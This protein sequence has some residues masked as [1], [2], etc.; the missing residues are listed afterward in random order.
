MA[1]GFDDEEIALAIARSMQ[2]AAPAPPPKPTTKPKPDPADIIEILDD[3]DEPPARSAQ[4]SSSYAAQ[5]HKGS[6]GSS[7]SSVAEASPPAPTRPGSAFLFDRAQLERERLARQA[8]LR[9]DIAAGKRAR[10]DDEGGE[11][12]EPGDGGAG[13]AGAGAG[14]GV[15]ASASAGGP[16]TKRQRVS[17]LSHAPRAD[18]LHS[19]RGAPARAEEGLFWAGALRQ[20]ANKHAEPAKDA[21]PVFRLTEVLG[22]RDEIAFAVVAAYVINLPWFYSFFNRETPVVVVTQDPAGNETIKEVLPNWIKTTP[23]L[24]GGRGCQHM[25]FML[26]FY[27]TGRLRVVVSTANV[28]EYDWR[29]VENS[30]WLQ[31]VPLRATPITHDSKAHDFPA[32]FM[33]VLHGVN[34]APALISL[35]KIGHDSLPLKRIED[36]RMKWDFSKV[37]VALI[38]SLAGKHEGWPK[39][40]LTG[41]PGLM[42]ALQYLGLRTPKGK[43]LALECQGSSI[44][45]YTTQWLNEF[46]VSARGESAESWL[47]VPR[48]RRTR[49]PLPPV[50]ILFPS[51]AT[52]QRSALGEPG[53]GTMFCR[54]AQWQ[55]AGFPR[56]LFHDSN[57]KRGGLLMHSKMI[58]ATFRDGALAA[59]SARAG[60]SRAHADASDDEIVEVPPPQAHAGWAYVGSHNFTPSAWGTLSGSA[61]NPV[62]NVTNYEL[63]VLVPLDTPQDADRVACWERPPRKYVLG[64]DEPWMQE[65]SVYFSEAAQG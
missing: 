25:K 44:G 58:L 60:S 33:R 8:R 45:N 65:E 52:V 34:V 42:K 48:T 11:P 64:T 1:D 6:D 26:L 39:V 10:D 41:H 37:K 46:Y 59:A 9:P 31:D 63:G 4:P 12:G 49:L 43:E 5:S 23:F 28:I 15:G 7:G 32:A 13:A 62:L 3:D 36:L 54:R 55:A 38:P 14:A 22:A 17:P 2:E 35:S 50:K 19:S 51:R 24:R 57:S 30:V 61:F 27:K 20:T 29:D 47:D 40:I 56:E 16:G 18:V 21:R 53:A